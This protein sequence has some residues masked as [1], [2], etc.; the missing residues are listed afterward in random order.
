[1]PKLTNP[2]NGKTV[3]V[4]DSSVELFTARGFKEEQK[5]RVTRK[6][7]QQKTEE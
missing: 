7:R 5:P 6:P 4:P 1:M 3:T 2:Y